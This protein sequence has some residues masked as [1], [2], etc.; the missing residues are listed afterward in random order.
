MSDAAAA[1]EDPYENVVLGKKL[2]FKAGKGLKV[3]KSK[4]SK[5]SKKRRRDGE[6][7]L[8]V[9][10]GKEEVAAVYVEDTRTDAQKR[11]DKVMEER[12]EKRLK[13]M[14][15]KSHR[16][17]VNDFNNLLASLSEHHDVPKVGNAG[18]G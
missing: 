9:S 3:K 15:A 7:A 1:A 11:Y 2:S 6:S 5:K 13:T 14:V 18:M 12:E 8:A 16:E 10:E 4:K 17:K